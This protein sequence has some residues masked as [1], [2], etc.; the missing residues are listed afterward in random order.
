[1]YRKQGAKTMGLAMTFIETPT[2]SRQRTQFA[3]D[4]EL[5]V[6]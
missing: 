2:F 5:R 6:L 3:A 4:D 1:M